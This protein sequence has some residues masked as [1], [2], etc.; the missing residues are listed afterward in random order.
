MDPIIAVYGPGEVT[1]ELVE[2]PCIGPSPRLRIGN[3]REEA[4][5][6]RQV[7]KV[8]QTQRAKD[9]KFADGEAARACRSLEEGG[10]GIERGVEHDV[11]G[12]V[13]PH[14]NGEQRVAE[15]TTCRVERQG[16]ESR[17]AAP[18]LLRCAP[19][20]RVTRRNPLTQLAFMAG[21]RLPA[22][23]D[24]LCENTAIQK[25]NP[26]IL[27][28]PLFGAFGPPSTHDDTRRTHPIG[29]DGVLRRRWAQLVRRTQEPITLETPSP[30]ESAAGR[31]RLNQIHP[32]DPITDCGEHGGRSHFRSTRW[33]PGEGGDPHRSRKNR[34]RC[35]IS[36][37][38][39]CHPKRKASSGPSLTR[40]RQLSENFVDFHFFPRP[41]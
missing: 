20:L 34:V 33:E 18:R 23:N 38:K 36:V 24:P 11:N 37:Q 15:A 32:E 26:H 16:V 39:C 3:R 22:T 1:Y 12:G 29:H 10:L 28:S 25:V 30:V 21:S 31:K 2:E 5:D 41:K 17:Q 40:L 6:R 35:L 19:A 13:K 14:I 27:C 7:G 4:R 8:E 9:A